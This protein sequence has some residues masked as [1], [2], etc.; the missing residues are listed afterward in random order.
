LKGRLTVL[1]VWLGVLL[2][3]NGCDTQ[4]S[5]QN[6]SLPNTVEFES[7]FESP[8]VPTATPWPSCLTLIEPVGN[9]V[10][11]YMVS[12]SSG[13]PIVGRP[14]FVA[15]GLFSSD[16][17][18][19][20]AALDQETAPQGITDENGMFFVADLPSNLYFLMIGDYPQP[21]MLHE[22]DNPANDLI[23]DWRE[24]EGEV[25]L[26]IIPTNILIPQEP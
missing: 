11:G 2:L 16:N 25:D 21:A 1:L 7:P 17:S 10:C 23:V 6:E 20:F 19:A 8:I 22:P 3:C 4:S 15:E 24:V 13:A 5:M 12:Q 26:G 9:T 18:V 14:V